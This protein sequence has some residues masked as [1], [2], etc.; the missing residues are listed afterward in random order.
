MG[1]L[2]FE[3]SLVIIKKIIYFCKPKNS[4]GLKPALPYAV[5]AFAEIQLY[6]MFIAKKSDFF[7]I[8]PL[9]QKIIDVYQKS[10]LHIKV[11]FKSLFHK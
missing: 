3:H 10:A 5:L 2:F 11:R 4:I 8:R 7:A 9:F 1:N 6:S